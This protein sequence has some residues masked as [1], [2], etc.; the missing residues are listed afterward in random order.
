MT[1]CNCVEALV[2]RKLEIAVICAGRR[3]LNFGVSIRIEAADD[4]AIS[5]NINHRLDEAAASGVLN[6]VATYDAA[7][8]HA[9][10]D[11]G[12][13]K[14]VGTAGDRGIAS[15]VQFLL[16]SIRAN[17][18]ITSGR[19]GNTTHGPRRTSATASDQFDARSIEAQVRAV[20]V[21]DAHPT[22]PI[23]RPKDCAAVAAT[24]AI[25]RYHDVTIRSNGHAG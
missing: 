15:H 6:G 9:A 24:A 7:A 14:D 8:N 1:R 22:F 5:G 23:W 16:R 10:K 4:R 11:T 13:T 20:R 21:H 25:R 18:D 17:A 19:H 3:V 12:V 2:H